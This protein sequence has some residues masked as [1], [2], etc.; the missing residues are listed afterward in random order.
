M[1]KFQDIEFR[2]NFIFFLV[3]I[4]LISIFF[5]KDYLVTV[6][7]DIDLDRADNIKVLE[8][9]LAEE[10]ISEKTSIVIKAI[11]FKNFR[12]LKKFIHPKK[13]LRL[14]PYPYIMLR[15]K[16]I[17]KNDITR[18]YRNGE[19]FTWGVDNNLAPI[20]LSF[21][22]YYE[23]YLYSDDF[24]NYDELWFNPINKDS[25]IIDNTR[26]SFPRGI[27]VEYHI[28][29]NFIDNKPRYLSLIKL[30]FE[31]YRGHWYLSAIIN[32]RGAK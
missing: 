18:L 17:K 20:E 12:T 25:N 13:G 9:K 22:E 19:I 4:I 28:F 14:S 23:Q 27:F 21:A 30:V 6:A 10:I 15:D 1:R 26:Q 11:K 7:N 2:D 31:E 5:T 8:P 16:I 24:A 29:D 32:V 3:V